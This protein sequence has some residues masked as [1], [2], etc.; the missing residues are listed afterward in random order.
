MSLV[1]PQIEGARFLAS[2][3]AAGLFDEPGFGKSAQA[4]VAADM[5]FARKILVVTTASAR[6]N[7]LREFGLWSA[8]DRRGV[9]LYTTKSVKLQP[10]DDV[11]VVG[12][13]NVIA[14]YILSQLTMQ[15]WDALI[16]D[17][18]HKAKSLQTKATQT[19]YGALAP[20]AK[21]VWCLTGTPVP[22]APNDLYPMLRTLFPEAL[23]GRNY[24]GFLARYCVTK[25]R[26]IS[27]RRIEVVTGGK[28]EAELGEKLKPFFLRRRTEGLPG[29]R[30]ATYPLRPE[31][32]H[33]D[34]RDA[35]KQADAEA[36]LEAAETGDTRE[37]EMHL[38]PLRRIT[39]H[40][41]AHAVASLIYEELQNGLD[42]V[43]LFHWHTDVGSTLR[44]KLSAFK[45]VG[46]D[47]STHPTARQEAVDRFQNDPATR[48]FVGQI[49]A[50]GEAIT[51]TA[52]NQCFFVEPSLVPKD[53]AQ[54]VR[55]IYRRGQTRLCLCRVAA[56]QGSI[57]EALMSIV[58][59]KVAS[60][61]KVLKDDTP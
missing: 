57:D 13:S 56:L 31:T 19:V 59:R 40:M 35:E 39:G 2:R 43:V 60:I 61:V 8:F 1:L 54:A 53:M 52:A 30:Y 14:P 22:N 49:A 34:F 32:L 3:R 46:I 45:P 48:V 29:M 6:A 44:M 58:T 42:K 33:V 21:Q 15:R 17:E 20:R 18:S 55:R 9:A 28:N 27:G 24:D 10:E 51:L 26:F 36:I 50:A 25:P 47:G 12:W 16:L 23:E 4:V 5:V 38:G 11:V 41:K 37:L 7:W